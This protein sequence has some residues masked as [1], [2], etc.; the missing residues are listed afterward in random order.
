[1]NYVDVDLCSEL[2]GH[3][4]IEGEAALCTCIYVYISM[5][6]VCICMYIYVCAT[7]YICMY[8]CVCVYVHIYV[9]IS[10]YTCSI[11][12][13]SREVRVEKDACFQVVMCSK[14]VC[15]SSAKSLKSR[16]VIGQ[17]NFDFAV[18]AGPAS[19]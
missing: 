4:S 17:F 14:H 6:T 3:C 1:M 2:C 5:Y 11:L 7:M 10:I 16:I 15:I 18:A 8:I 19:I 13:T 12:C 9:S